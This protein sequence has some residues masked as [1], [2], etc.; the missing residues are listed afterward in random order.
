M[1][2]APQFYL[3]ASTVS[4]STASDQGT[5]GAFPFLLYEALPHLCGP[6]SLCQNASNSG[7]LSCYNKLWINCLCFS[8]MVSLCL[9]PY[10]QPERAKVHLGSLLTRSPA[11]AREP[12]GGTLGEKH[13]PSHC[14]CSSGLCLCPQAC[15]SLRTKPKLS[16]LPECQRWFPTLIQPLALRVSSS[17]LKTP[18]TSCDNAFWVLTI[19]LHCVHTL[20]FLVLCASLS[21]YSYAIFPSSIRDP[22]HLNLPSSSLPNVFRSNLHTETFW[23]LI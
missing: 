14:N 13:C 21:L 4:R 6:L 12:L 1:P 11:S 7:W 17:S 20:F 2:Q 3:A 23:S 16:Q 18:R 10:K 9:F 22:I 8:H 19:N 15:G 5:L